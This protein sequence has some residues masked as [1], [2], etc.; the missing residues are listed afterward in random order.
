MFFLKFL[1]YVV[2]SCLPTNK[3]CINQIIVYFILLLFCYL[4]CIFDL[5]VVSTRVLL[6]IYWT[7]YSN[8]PMICHC[9][10]LWGEVL[11]VMCL[12]TQIFITVCVHHWLPCVWNILREGC[13]GVL[14]FIQGR[15][16]LQACL[17]CTCPWMILG[18]CGLHCKCICTSAW[19]S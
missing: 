2:M 16:F 4:F 17:S 8:K 6:L 11:W 15:Y 3:F 14:G 1:F 13:F 5:R 9:F 18:L 10:W 7:F 19:K 12:W